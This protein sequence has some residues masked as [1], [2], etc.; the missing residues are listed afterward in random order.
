MMFSLARCMQADSTLQHH[1]DLIDCCCHE[2]PRHLW[3]ACY[4]CQ[5]VASRLLIC[6]DCS[7]LLKCPA[8]PLSSRARCSS[9]AYDARMG[10][11]ALVHECCKHRVGGPFTMLAPACIDLSCLD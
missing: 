10:F 8:Q 6:K 5:S 7:R 11:Q 9:T 2:F 4:L 3:D 1:S